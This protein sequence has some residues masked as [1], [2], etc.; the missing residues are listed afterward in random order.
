MDC[1]D[2]QGIPA[3]GLAQIAAEAA[4]AELPK[5]AAVAEPAVDDETDD[6]GA[7]VDDDGE[8]VALARGQT[9][10][11]AVPACLA[12]TVVERDFYCG[13]VGGL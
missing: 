10:R 11:V 4:P 13:T 6:L 1:A 7:A 9:V 2:L 8:M 5:V 12:A 3:I